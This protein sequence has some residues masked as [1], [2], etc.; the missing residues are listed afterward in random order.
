MRI[1]IPAIALVV[2]ACGRKADDSTVASP[3]IPE[4]ASVNQSTPTS[5]AP[6]VLPL[7]S[8]PK[9]VDRLILAGYTPHSDHL[10]PPGMDKCPM[11][12]DAKAVM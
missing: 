12:N 5:K 10:H 8:D 7:P 2:C 4:A 9:E 1:L 11:A 6:M 3:A